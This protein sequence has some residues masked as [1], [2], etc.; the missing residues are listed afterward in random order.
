V[1][2]VPNSLNLLGFSGG[3]IRKVGCKKTDASSIASFCNGNGQ[4]VALVISSRFVPDN[5]GDYREFLNGVNEF[6]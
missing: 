6:S 2:P 4:G 1:S 5:E 3:I